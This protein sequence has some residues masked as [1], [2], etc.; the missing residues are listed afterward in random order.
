[1]DNT[2]PPARK[3]RRRVQS[4]GSAGDDIVG[5][6][7]S[8]PHPYGVRPA[9]NELLAPPEQA[10]TRRDGLGAAAALTDEALLALL[11]A[12][13]APS[14]AR[15]VACSR[16]LYVFGHH[17]DLWR[18]LALAECGGGKASVAFERSWKDT[19]ARLVAA[20]GGRAAAPPAPHV[21]LRVAGIFSDALFRPW[22]CCACDVQ[23]RWLAPNNVPRRAALSVADFVAEYEAPNRPVIITDVVTQWPAFK[24]WDREYLAAACGGALFRATSLGASSAAA[25]TMA[26]YH[27]YA[28]QVTE[29]APLYLFERAFAALAPQLAKDYEQPK[30][31]RPSSSSSSSSSSEGGGG[32]GG[33]IGSGSGAEQHPSDLFSLL[34]EEARPDH[35]WL[36]AGPAKSGS[37]FHIDP[38]QTNAWNACIRG[39]KR[40]LLYP[41]GCPPPGVLA[42]A[43]G[44]DVTLPLSLGEWFLA[45]FRIHEKQRSAEPASVRPLECVVGPGEMLFVPHGWWHCVFNLDD[46]IALTQNYV[47][48]SNLRDVLDFLEH[49]P[50]QIS[51][52]RDRAES[53]GAEQL[54][55]RFVEALRERH[56]ALLERV[57]AE[58]ARERA[59]AA[60]QQRAA[61]VARKVEDAARARRQA[62][63]ARPAATAAA[64]QATSAPAPF[65]FGF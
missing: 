62:V 2:T 26:D 5:T 51:G 11:S 56:P 19:C 52:V 59:A 6:S 64:S 41:P 45:F 27:S 1:M 57:L 16:A 53:V 60:T 65:K 12:V 49:K 18:N 61:E 29:E 20:R 13:D 4:E 15:L 63:W 42:S 31:F 33:G 10:R 54:L 32:S 47:S 36:I 24:L 38:N 23:P 7:L 46:S 50:D 39:R 17:A 35:K 48:A 44:A 3:R 34:G 43:D 58:Q 25:F 14:L 21:P 9:G 55:P 22:C 37:V 28:A 8:A 30:Y 40:W